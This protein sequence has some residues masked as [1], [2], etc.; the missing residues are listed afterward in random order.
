[1]TAHSPY[2][3]LDGPGG[4]TKYPLAGGPTVLGRAAD[5]GI[6]IDPPPSL[7]W[8]A[9]TIPAAT[10]AAVPPEDPPAEWPRA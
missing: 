5:A 1:M 6:R 7:A 9:G 10:A 2:L 8:P 4:P 3:L